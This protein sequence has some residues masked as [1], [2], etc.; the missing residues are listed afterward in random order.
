MVAIDDDEDSV[1]LL[2]VEY[3]MNV[4]KRHY[5]EAEALGPLIFLQR[6]AVQFH[7]NTCKWHA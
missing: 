7:N 4:G 1:M 5:Q 3:L 6:I 2:G